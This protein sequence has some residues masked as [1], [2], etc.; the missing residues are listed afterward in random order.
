MNLAQATETAGTLGFPSKMPGTAYGIPAKECKTGSKLAQIPGSV[1]ANCYANKGNYV[2]RDVQ[3]SQYTRLAALDNPGWVD[4]MIA[5]LNIKH[6]P[7]TKN[8]QGKPISIGW[9]RWHD[10]GD[11]QSVE[12]LAKICWVAAGTPHIKHWLPTREHKILSDYV[13]AGGIV[14][15]NLVIRVSATMV[16]GNPTARWSHTSTV[17]D[18]LVPDPRSGTRICG[19]R[20]RDNQCGPCR[21]CWDPAIKNVS[22][23][24][25]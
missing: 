5:Q 16:D 18:K 12:H 13:A 14:P 24:L 9:H 10:S 6:R 11:L 20:D 21:D 22:Y 2:F 8:K 7:G 17:H 3:K 4:A 25:H 1:C 15:D 23:P 19:A